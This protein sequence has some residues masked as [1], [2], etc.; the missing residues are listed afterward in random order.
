MAFWHHEKSYDEKK[1]E[2]LSQINDTNDAYKIFNII[3]NLSPEMQA[4]KEIMI[5]AVK[6]NGVVL[7]YA[8]YELK[9]DHYIIKAAVK[10]SPYALK[11]ATD[12]MQDNEKV[13][14]AAL[15]AYNA[16]KYH[17]ST[18]NPFQYASDEL[19]NN[20]K[21][22]KMAIIKDAAAFEYAG[23]NIKSNR[24]IA[25]EAI[26][27]NGKM[28]QYV[29]DIFKSDIS[30]VKEIHGNR[31]HVFE[32]ASDDI[33]N[34][35][36]FIIDLLQQEESDTNIIPHMS[37]DLK[38]DK[39]FIMEIV[40]YAP[41]TIIKNSFF[42]ADKDVLLEALKADPSSSVLTVRGYQYNVA[43]DIL[44]EAAKIAP[45]AILQV[46]VGVAR[47]LKQPI[48]IPK[49]VLIECINQDSE[50]IDKVF[51]SSMNIRQRATLTPH[52]KDSIFSD[53]EIALLAIKNSGI[54]LQYFY[55]AYKDKELVSEAV[56]QNGEAIQY[57][58][59]ELKSDP[60]IIKL[61]I[62]QNPEAIKFVPEDMKEYAQ[63]VI[64]GT[65]DSGN[66]ATDTANQDDG[67]NTHES[68]HK[69]GGKEV[70]HKLSEKIEGNG[71][72]EYT[73]EKDG[74]V[75]AKESVDSKDGSHT[76]IQFN[77]NGK[78][79]VKDV[80][81]ADGTHEHIELNAKGQEWKHTCVDKNGHQTTE[82]FNEN[83]EKVMDIEINKDG[84]MKIDGKYISK[85]KDVFMEF[86][87]GSK[88]E[89]DHNEAGEHIIKHT[90]A[91]GHVDMIETITEQG[92]I[93]EHF[94]NEIGLLN[95]DK[96]NTSGLRTVEVYDGI[97]PNADI[98]HLLAH[99]IIDEFGIETHHYND[100]ADV[101]HDVIDTTGLASQILVMNILI[102]PIVLMHNI[103]LIHKQ[104]QQLY[105]C[106]IPKCTGILTPSIV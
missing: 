33:K 39:D 97:V 36:N 76:T 63:S 77:K 71:N 93:I 90:A 59:D 74:K 92:T 3:K 47:M 56:K 70:I 102:A 40:K 35:K 6:K 86:K 19:K 57:A 50:F 18:S 54:S 91:D 26:T 52:G 68:I 34:N 44:Y 7:K 95:M 88:L 99:D 31:Y 10:K 48:Y 62:E 106:S 89:S 13:V 25:I 84:S 55:G 94:A 1:A 83:G 85:S 2:L 53:K 9:N 51:H 60:D 100:G 64:D 103:H 21:I 67:I 37:D 16:L 43:D 79:I 65:G 20:E 69:V 49:K 42:A 75:I 45:Q 24:G 12:E 23:E 87:D 41:Y 46:K 73:H 105:S 82:Y 104:F 4:D 22:A 38:G 15:K 72:A 11:Y 8:S 5:N 61:A 78:E 66:D 101:S 29:D 96:I 81:K 32:Y 27:K 30:F 28:M 80:V 17:S 98:N 14:T 58:S